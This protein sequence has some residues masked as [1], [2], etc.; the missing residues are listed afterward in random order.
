MSD[1][2]ADININNISK[3]YRDT[4]AVDNISFDVKQG[5]FLT[6]LG[7]SGCG[8]TTTPEHDCGICVAHFRQY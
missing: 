2:A 4:V 7:P 1:T 8:K 3:H 6:L 5:E